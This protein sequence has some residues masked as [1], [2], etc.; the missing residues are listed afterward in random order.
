MSA[1][2]TAQ[3]GAPNVSSL[4][5][6]LT[7]GGAGAV[8]GLLIVLV[9]QFTLPTVL[10]NRAA[11]LETAIQQV[12]PGIARYDT[13]YLHNGALTATLPSGVDGRKLEKV[14]AGLDASGRRVGFA[15]PTSEPGFQDAIDLIF[16]FDPAK[17]GTLGLAILG[18][19][20]TPGLGD[21]IENAEWLEQFGDA[22]TPLQ[23]VKAGHAES[24][25]EV[26]MITGA[27]ISSRTVIGAINKAVV[28]W[29]P[30]IEAWQAGAG[31]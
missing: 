16:G 21:K 5:L 29:T 7:L 20:E 25:A 19:R 1:A 2:P 4:R 22:Q 8:A 17:P 28:R 14:Y 18:S 23:P 31:S 12:L 11:R 9:F 27:T 3:A 24:P 6:L 30:L 10:A 15:I 26:D 13:L